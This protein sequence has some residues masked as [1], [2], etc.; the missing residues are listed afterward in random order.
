M[1]ETEVRVTLGDLKSEIRNDIY[2]TRREIKITHVVLAMVICVVTLSIIVILA[3]SFY[4]LNTSADFVGIEDVR[5]LKNASLVAVWGGSVAMV[6]ILLI[7][8]CIVIENNY[9]KESQ[10][11][12]VAM[13]KLD[14]INRTDSTVVSEEMIRGLFEDIV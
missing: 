3:S 11:L 5:V 12:G 7:F 8:G 4:A 13:K 1:S 10:A 2:D 14:E 6:G 9:R